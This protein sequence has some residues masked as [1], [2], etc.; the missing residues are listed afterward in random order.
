[1]IKDGGKKV[2]FMDSLIKAGA[3]PLAKNK[4]GIEAINLKKRPSYFERIF[5]AISFFC[6]NKAYEHIA[7]DNVG[8]SCSEFIQ[9]RN[10][11]EETLKS[12]KQGEPY[13]KEPVSMKMQIACIGVLPS[14]KFL[15]MLDH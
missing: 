14:E 5:K 2:E 13:F 10:D 11:L 8:Y 3:D 7:E 6:E 4:Y 9:K 15:S 1:M 12:C